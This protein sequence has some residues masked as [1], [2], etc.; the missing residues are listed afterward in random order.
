MDIGM[1]GFMALNY[2]NLL[3]ILC[4]LTMI[5]CLLS[6]AMYFSTVPISAYLEVD[7]SVKIEMRKFRTYPYKRLSIY[8]T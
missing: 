1:N 4:A 8:E 3:L 5:F 7:L 6:M 2:V